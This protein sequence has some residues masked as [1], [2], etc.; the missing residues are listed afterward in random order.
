MLPALGYWKIR[1]V[2]MPFLILPAT[3][4]TFRFCLACR[5]M[6]SSVE[7]PGSEFLMGLDFPNLLYYIDGDLKLNQSG[8][9]LEY[10]S[11]KHNMSG[12]RRRTV[13]H[14]LQYEIVDLRTSFTMTCYNLNF[15][16]M[17]PGF[18]ETLKQKLS[19]FEVY[20]GE[21][22]WLTGDENLPALR[23]YISSKT[24]RARPCCAP[25][26]RR[27]FDD[28]LFCCGVATFAL[29]RSFA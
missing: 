12:R 13:L 2:N 7:V 18:M 10:I 4:T 1:G 23:D 15:E 24:F 9:V 29:Y 3:L 17:K 6:S 14:M 11:D 28:Y 27:Q 22:E 21:K 5:A 16:K 26:A 25:M 8:A 20:L 19:N